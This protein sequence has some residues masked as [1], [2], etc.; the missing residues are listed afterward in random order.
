VPDETLGFAIR[1]VEVIHQSGAPSTAVRL[2]RGGKT[3][4]YSGDTEWTEALIDIADGADLF[5]LECY[6]Y[7]R[8]VPGHMNFPRLREN[9]ERLRARRIMLTHMNPSMLAHVEEARAEGLLVA[10]DGFVLEF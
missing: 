2:M 6:D 9:R 10:E 5:I 3:L 8:E 1:T 4:S 7:S